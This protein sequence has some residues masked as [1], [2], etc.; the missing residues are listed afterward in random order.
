MLT[1]LICNATRASKEKVRENIT[2]WVVARGKF[3]N[4]KVP[5]GGYGFL[6]LLLELIS[7]NI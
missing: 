2:N 6:F 5:L 1:R 3:N 4:L 7:N